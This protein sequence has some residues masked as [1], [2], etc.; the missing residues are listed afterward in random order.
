MNNISTISNSF[1][2]S[3]NPTSSSL[4]SSSSSDSRDVT[5]SVAGNALKKL[6]SFFPSKMSSPSSFFKK[7][8]RV[9][10]QEVLENTDECNL[11]KHL[12]RVAVLIDVNAASRAGTSVAASGVQL[13]AATSHAVSLAGLGSA[14]ASLQ[15]LQG[16]TLIYFAYK[17]LPSSKAALK[18]AE[19]RRAEDPQTYELAKLN[20]RNHQ[21]LLVVGVLFLLLG[22]I[23]VA[24]MIGAHVA[25]S[26]MA[27]SALAASATVMGGVL[28]LVCVARGVMLMVRSIKN[29]KE[30][31]AFQ[32]EFVKQIEKGNLAEAI[33][34]V[35][36]DET[37]EINWA[38]CERLVGT[39]TKE[40]LQEYVANQDILDKNLLY[41][42]QKDMV[43][44]IVNGVYE[45]KL[46]QKIFLSIGVLMMLGGVAGTAATALTPLT[47]GGSAI[48]LAIIG[49]S[50][51]SN[52]IFSIMEAAWIPVD[53]SKAFQWVKKIVQKFDSSMSD[54]IS[55]KLPYKEFDSIFNSRGKEC[56]DRLDHD[57]NFDRSHES[58]LFLEKLRTMNFQFFKKNEIK[59]CG[60]LFDPKLK[61]GKAKCDL[62][63]SIVNKVMKEK[64]VCSS[65]FISRKS[66]R[67]NQ[68]K[69][70]N[71]TDKFIEDDSIKQAEH[72]IPRFPHL[73]LKDRDH[74]I[75]SYSSNSSTTIFDSV[76]PQFQKLYSNNPGFFNLILDTLSQQA[77]GK[78]CEEI[79]QLFLERW[80]KELSEEGEGNLFL[81]PIINTTLVE[82][83][84]DGGISVTYELRLKYIDSEY[85]SL[86]AELEQPASFGIEQKINPFRIQIEIKPDSYDNQSTIEIKKMVSDISLAEECLGE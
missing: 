3:R 77:Q 48:A 14:I 67:P 54:V 13:S 16:I 71:I 60:L 85:L 40:L 50:L 59:I 37:G 46:Q 62:A 78:I 19:I 64:F 66:L 24:A 75:S 73:I 82:L 27:L 5:S 28:S 6:A 8:G 35:V 39:E 86:L 68:E 53:S 49:A 4:G 33:D 51:A 44:P 81:Q 38:R 2:P 22:S 84:Q 47:G 83:K 12:N 42:I 20:Y 63:Q 32:T 31:N 34:L 36:K 15:F 1:G 41:N 69:A 9:V 26:A 21:S 30:L 10:K 79:N 58:I 29:L 25:I 17:L 56:L 74:R 55:K 45:R 52:G 65:L 61:M 11:S 70:D 43:V 18:E 76:Y 23:G 7:E 57:K 72:D 80:S